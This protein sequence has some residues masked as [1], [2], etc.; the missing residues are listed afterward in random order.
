MRFD[1][2]ESADPAL[3]AANLALSGHRH[4]DGVRIS[5]VEL[6]VQEQPAGGWEAAA[7]VAVASFAALVITGF[8]F[9]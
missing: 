3:R 4:R 8:W 6:R 7:Y 2:P 9:F 5:A 1:D